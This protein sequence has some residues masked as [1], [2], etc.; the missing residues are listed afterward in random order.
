MAARGTEQ[1]E[2]SARGARWQL[3]ALALAALASFSGGVYWVAL[4]RPYGLLTY[5]ARP[6]LDLG[7]I[8]G[9][10]RADGWH[11]ALPLVALWLAYALAALIAPHVRSG[12]ALGALAGGGTV[13]AVAVLLWLY[14]IT[15]ADIF[16]YALYGLAQHA[17]ANPLVVPPRGVIGPPLLDY[18]AWPDHPSPYGP[19]WQGLAWLVT[20]VSG[21]RLLPGILLFK[22]LLAACHLLNAWLVARIAD[23]IG[24]MR[25]GV[26]ALLYGWNPLLLYETVGNGHNDIAMLTPLLLALLAL[27]GRR[28]AL[29][30]PLVVLAALAK[31]VGALWLPV[32][33]L[34]W[35]P[36]AWRA[37]R[38]RAIGAAGLG[39]AVLVALCLGP[40]WAGGA[41]LAGLRRQADLY[42]TSLG[43]LIMLE[44]PRRSPSI[45]PRELLDRVKGG[46]LVFVA[47]TILAARPRDGGAREVARATFDVTLG[48]LLVGALWFQPWYLVPLVGLAPLVGPTRRA[49][50]AIYALGATGSYI[51]YF[52][53]WPAFGWDTDPLV[54][55][56]WAV[57]VAHGPVLL[58]VTTIAVARLARH[59][60]GAARASRGEKANAP[61]STPKANS[62]PR[63]RPRPMTPTHAAAIMEGW[64]RHPGPPI[65]RPG[66][67]PTTTHTKGDPMRYALVIIGVVMIAIGGVW[68]LQGTNILPGS[69]MTGQQQWAII[70]AIVLIVGVAL[71]VVGARMIA[72]YRPI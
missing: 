3:P 34:G 70:G 46:A 54:I 48:Y 72:R 23:A 59:L 58:A 20:A 47:L 49:L 57:G 33:A 35:L 43:G 56:R 61:P 67:A 18:S 14:P 2:T 1:G 45:A 8:G 53:T 7:K 64:C 62:R 21:D 71:L 10:G 9:Y 65:A 69:F 44:L 36:G 38:W 25:P 28:D 26:A 50:A 15:A 29:A 66:R 11:F 32:L 12:R 52:Y 41:A 60:L 31:W 4:V 40:F 19:L 55:Q 24:D 16:N 51:V 39:M 68:I 27:A 22:G 5:V 13:G 30:P 37:R 17:G 6:L 42:T 63:E